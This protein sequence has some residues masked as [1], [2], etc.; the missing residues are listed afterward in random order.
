MERLGDRAV[1]FPRPHAAPARILE[2]VRAWPGVRDVVIAAHDVAVY[3]DAEPADFTAQIAEL[4][5]LEIE[6]STG[7]EVTVRVVYDGDDLAAVAAATRLA[8]AGVIELHAA[9]VYEVA[10]VG[11]QPGFAYLDG[12]DPRLEVA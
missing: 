7:R 4:A 3:C 1:R 9:G 10:S 11:F 2:A 8:V 12:L 6:P 5:T